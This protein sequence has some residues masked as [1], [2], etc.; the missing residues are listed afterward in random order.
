MRS[1]IASL[2]PALG[3]QDHA[4]WPSA[5]HR[6]SASEKECC[7][8]S[9]PPLPASTFVTIAI[10]PSSRGGMRGRMRL[11]CPTPQAEYFSQQDWTRG[12]ALKA[13]VNLVFRRSGFAVEMQDQRDDI[14]HTRTDLPDG[15]TSKPHHSVTHR[16]F[17]PNSQLRPLERKPRQF[18]RRW[19]ERE[20][21]ALPE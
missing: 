7:D 19:N 12:I 15:H 4:A 8:V 9:R 2:A 5:K 10:R 3:R 6:S 14:S 20:R 17:L 11:I 16:D 18:I 21:A 13:R 1:I